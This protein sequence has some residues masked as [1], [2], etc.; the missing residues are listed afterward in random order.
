MATTSRIGEKRTAVDHLS[1]DA[2]TAKRV[3]W[4]S[5][6]FTVVGPYQVRVTN[7]SYGFKKDKHAYV[8]GVEDREGIVVPAECECPADVH[9]DPDCKHKVALASVGGP[10]VLNAAV[11]FENPAPA[12]DDRPAV[13]T[14]TD[15][16][17]VD[18]GVLADA[19]LDDNEEC[20]ECAEL[21][22]LP[23]F[24]CY[25]DQREAR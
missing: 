7:A 8:V 22:D 16:L 17:A 21:S 23:C 1:F 18:G 12:T 6:E 24:D 9:R 5:W 4:E 2:R 19:K 3:A 25:C 14:G 10:T 11:I 20:K 15:L 13:K